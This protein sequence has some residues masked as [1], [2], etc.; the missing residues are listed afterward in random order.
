MAQ[1]TV[2]LHRRTAPRHQTY[3][4][5]IGYRSHTNSSLGWVALYMVYYALHKYK[6]YC[7]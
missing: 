2:A 6:N 7:H 1:R 3:P 4:N 5:L